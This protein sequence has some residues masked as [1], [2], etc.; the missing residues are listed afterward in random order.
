MAYRHL[1]GRALQLLQNLGLR[2]IDRV[3]LD[4]QPVDSAQRFVVGLGPDI[5]GGLN[6]VLTDDDDRQQNELEKGLGDPGDDYDD[7]ARVDGGGQ[8]D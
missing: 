4:G 7:L 1:G 6:H 8:R 3:D 5:V 2:F